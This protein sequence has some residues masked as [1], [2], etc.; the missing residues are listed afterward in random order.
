MSVIIRISYNTEEELAGVIRRLSPVV[1][2]WR[3]S[4]NQTGKYKKA[5]VILKAV[6]REKSE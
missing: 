1:E 5:Y 6:G 3:R 4:G 2:K